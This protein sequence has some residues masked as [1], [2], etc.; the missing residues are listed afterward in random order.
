MLNKI[1]IIAHNLEGDAVV[2]LVVNENSANDVPVGAL[3]LRFYGEV[4][5]DAACSVALLKCAPDKDPGVFWVDVGDS[6]DLFEA[7]DVLLIQPAQGIVRIVYRRSS[8]ANSL[9]LTAQ[10]NSL[11]LMCPQPPREQDDVNEELLLRQIDC[12]PSNAEELCL[13][14]GEPTLHSGRLIRVLSRIAQHCSDCHVHVL[15]NARLCS[16]QRLVSELVS[17]GVGSLSFGVPLYA[18]TP[19]V[20]DYIVQSRGAFDETVSGIYNLAKSGVNIEIRIV[21]HKQTI[22]ELAR[23]VDYIYNK[24]PFVAHVAFMGMEHMG[25]V[26]KNWDALWVSPLDYQEE[27]LNAVRYL[28]RRK[29]Y[30][31]V[32]NLPFCLTE[33]SVWPFLRNSI[34]DYKVDFR[35]E[36]DC[37]KKR[38]DCGGLFHYQRNAMSVRPID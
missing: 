6:L 25:F 36:C 26:K 30:C 24:F 37:C 1:R 10:C 12:I 28:H 7:D 15:S 19:Y 14:G 38:S 8:N 18:A 17:T 34:S 13:T 29:I 2:R 35:D 33:K 20:H 32:Y 16:N 9:F 31:S 23:L 21:L 4:A 22:P 27:L 5:Q 3:A 11:C